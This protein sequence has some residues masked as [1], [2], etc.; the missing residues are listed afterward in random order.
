MARSYSYKNN[1]LF[2]EILVHEL[3][4]FQVKALLKAYQNTVLGHSTSISP[5]IEEDLKHG[6]EKNQFVSKVKSL[7]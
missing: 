3:I 4:I 6:I 7:E 5:T 2:S 1:V